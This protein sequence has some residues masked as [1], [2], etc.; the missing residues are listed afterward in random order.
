[1]SEWQPGYAKLLASGEL[2]KWELSAKGFER[3][4]ELQ[5]DWIAAHANLA[6]VLLHYLNK[7][8]K[9]MIHL[10]RADALRRE[11]EQAAKNAPGTRQGPPGLVPR[12][13]AP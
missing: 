10:A 11:Q 1:M 13:I 2:E 12:P 4:V 7:P 9:A 8:E 3:A 5:P 6:Q